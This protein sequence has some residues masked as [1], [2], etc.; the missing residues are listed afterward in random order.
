MQQH[1]FEQLRN[2][3][4]IVKNIN[5]GGCGIAALVM[6]RWLK[7]NQQIEAEIIYGFDPMSF[8]YE[9]NLRYQQTNQ[10]E[11]AES[12]MHVF[13]S[14]GGN[15]FD[16]EQDV[17]VDDV[18]DRT[19]TV[20]EQHLVDSINNGSWLDWFKRTDIIPVAKKYNIDISDIRIN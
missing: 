8:G 5:C 7:T 16:C 13:L 2:D 11:C 18:F 17:P 14:L 15:D 9:S 12:A 19:L 6:Y 1:T 3:L 10:P 20:T 4:A